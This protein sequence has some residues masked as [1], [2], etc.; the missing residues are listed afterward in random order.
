MI[1]LLKK[2]KNMTI[3]SLI[4]YILSSNDIFCNC[5]E[6]IFNTN[7]K[8]QKDTQDKTID[9][10]KLK[11]NELKNLPVYI[12]R[13]NIRKLKNNKN[14]AKLEENPILLKLSDEDLSIIKVFLEKY[15]ITA[16]DDDINKSY[17]LSYNVGLENCIKLNLKFKYRYWK[18]HEFDDGEIDF[19]YNFKNDLLINSEPSTHIIPSK[20]LEEKYNCE[21]TANHKNITNTILRDNKES[22][23]KCIYY[24]RKSDSNFIY[25][26]GSYQRFYYFY[27]KEK[28]DY[29]DYGSLARFSDE[30]YCYE[31]NFYYKSE[32]NNLDEIKKDTATIDELL[33]NVEKGEQERKDNVL[34]LVTTK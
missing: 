18:H 27:N 21:C 8:M 29:L 24:I 7:N 23:I 1:D 12:R 11:I 22:L 31:H 5:C 19:F 34:S 13:K 28:N 9:P 4:F 33:K 16:S 10:S 17:N 30:C 32:T 20:E 26:I 25:N 6:C 3:F 2:N 14:K 15:N